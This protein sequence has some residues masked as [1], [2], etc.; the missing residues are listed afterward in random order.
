[1]VREG[2]PTLHEALEAVVGIAVAPGPDDVLRAAV[3]AAAGL[4]GARYGAGLLL[5]EG[6]GVRSFV[7][8]GLDPHDAARLPDAPSG[9]GLIGVVLEADGPV[10][11]D[12]VRADPRAVGFPLDHVAMGPLLGVPVS[13]GSRTVGALLV[14]RP[15]GES[16]FT[17]G[18]ASLLATLARQ[19]GVVLAT[20][21]ALAD[22]ERRVAAQ[23]EA[24]V[25]QRILQVTA[26]AANEATTV[27]EA[28]QV[29]VDEVCAQTGWDVGHAWV[30]GPEGVLVPTNVWHLSSPSRFAGLLR[31]TMQTVCAPGAGLLGRVFATGRPLWMHPIIDDPALP[32][33]S[34]IRAA[35]LRSVYLLPVLA[36]REVVAVL[37]FFATEPREVDPRFFAVMADVVALLGRVVER[38]RAAEALRRHAEELEAA[39][40]RLR[41]AD[42]VKSDFVSMASHELRTPLTSIVGFASTLRAYWDRTPDEEKRTYI[43]VIERQAER[44]SRL[45]NDLLAMSRI[46]SGTLVV[47]AEPVVVADAVAQVLHDLDPT[48]EPVEVQVD[49][50]LTVIADPDHLQQMLLNY[51]TNAQKYGAPPIRIEGR[52]AGDAVVLAVVDHGPGVPEHFVPSLFERFTQASTGVARK[53]KGTGL[54]LSIVRGLAQANGGDAWYEPAE[55]G[56]RFCLRLPAAPSPGPRPQPGGRAQPGG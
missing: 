3:D 22:L 11:V 28:M 34:A 51:L 25:L 19:T 44:L 5:D 39:N 2:E 47:R 20:R 30:P 31:A 6:G 56:A 17:P 8:L 37:E 23:R 1:V 13:D 27:E 14:A 21:H 38:T 43:E 9:R 49:A 26:A 16:P 35:G 53:A 10:R 15:A 54:G 32:R 36:G 7:H 4:T 24:E 33:A 46:E 52:R 42:R 45:V 18:E 48:A 29:C 50:D 55:P 41:E 12:D 40:R